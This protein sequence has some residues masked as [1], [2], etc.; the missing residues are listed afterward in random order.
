M[1]KLEDK[2]VKNFSSAFFKQEN[3]LFGEHLINEL[4]KIFDYIRIGVPESK[5]DKFREHLSERKSFPDLSNILNGYLR[6]S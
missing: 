5:G 6:V 4:Q 1:D 2:V 3:F